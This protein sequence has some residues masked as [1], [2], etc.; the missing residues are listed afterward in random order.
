MLPLMSDSCILDVV[1]NDYTSTVVLDL[2]VNL[3]SDIVP[4]INGSVSIEICGM[5]SPLVDALGL[6]S[7]MH[8]VWIQ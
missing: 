8:H 1:Y 4:C 6:Q 3:S 7:S 2:D 5:L